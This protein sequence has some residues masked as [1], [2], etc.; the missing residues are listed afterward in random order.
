[1]SSSKWEA[2]SQ[3]SQVLAEAQVKYVATLASP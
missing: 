1:M 3:P 2:L